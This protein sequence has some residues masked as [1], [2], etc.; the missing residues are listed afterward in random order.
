MHVVDLWLD[1]I[2]T[3]FIIEFTVDIM[4]SYIVAE[5]DLLNGPR[6]RYNTSLYM[7][8]NILLHD[9]GVMTMESDN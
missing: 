4:N 9:K 1:N 7:S 5:W 3:G 6:G 2:T 8:I